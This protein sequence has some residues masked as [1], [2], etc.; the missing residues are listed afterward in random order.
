M[1]IFIINCSNLKA[2]GGLQVADSICR[3]LFKYKSH[4]FVVVLSKFLNK[5][6][7]SI[8]KYENVEVCNYDIPNSFNS[9]VLG[10]DKYLDELVKS[11]NV[12]AVLTVFG[13][14]RWKPSVPHLS[15]FALPQLVIPESPYFK[16]MDRM[17]KIKWRLWCKIRKWSLKRS[18]DYF[19]TENEYIT[20]RLSDLIKTKELTTVTNYYNQVFDE[21]EKWIKS[22]K[23]PQ[24][25]GITCLSVSTNSTHKNFPITIEVI[26][27][28]F[29][30]HPNF[31]VRFV[32][33]FDVDEMPVPRELASNFVFVGKV[34]VREVPY[35]YEQADI[36][37]MPSLL[38]CFTATYP[39]AMKMGVPIVTT[40]L[41]FARGL[42]GEAACY[43]SA[44]DASAAADAIYKV[45]T[46]KE[47][48]QQLIDNGKKQ[49]ITYDNYEQRASKLINMVEVI[50]KK[51]ER[52]KCE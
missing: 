47:Y 20:Q 23:L 10:R 32:F 21:P 50:S 51:Y 39:E 34:D 45:S 30:N 11:K 37:F 33:T 42:C 17:E 29:L 49:L 2:G 44:V 22:I 3:Q 46:N 13:P 48:A 8:Q 5:T 15:G 12:T 38:E 6:A 26:K 28:L 25:D 18:A 31:K 9:I 16:R 4:R 19:W 52:D 14:S 36:M 41:E 40:D 43:Y 24:F 7:E 27:K 35:L 1:S